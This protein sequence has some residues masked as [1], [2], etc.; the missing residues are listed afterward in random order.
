MTRKAIN[1]IQRTM[2]AFGKR[3][4]DGTPITLIDLAASRV[5]DQS[6]EDYNDRSTNR[7]HRPAGRCGDSK[8]LD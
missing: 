5:G 4:T 8:V 6:V 3:T 1:K 7:G 2:A